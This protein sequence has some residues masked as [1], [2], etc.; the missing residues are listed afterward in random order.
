MY[1]RVILPTVFADEAPGVLLHKL[2]GYLLEANMTGQ[3]E[4][5]EFAV[6]VDNGGFQGTVAGSRNLLGALEPPL[7]P[8]S[9][10]FPNLGK[11]PRR[12]M[13]GKP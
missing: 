1:C 10:D 2:L 9:C 5:R 8:P 13:S 4:L 6:T 7:L 12:L 3:T 11:R